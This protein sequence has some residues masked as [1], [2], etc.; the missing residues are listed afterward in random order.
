MERRCTDEGDDVVRLP[1]GRGAV[2]MEMQR[3]ARTGAV[4][5]KFVDRVT[6][7]AS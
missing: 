1:V 5:L 3:V 2:A 6:V 4:A 7:R